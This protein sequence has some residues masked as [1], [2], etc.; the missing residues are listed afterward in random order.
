[1][2]EEITLRLRGENEDLR[3]KL[4]QSQQEVDG[5][6]ESVQKIETTS[7]GAGDAIEAAT[8]DLRAEFAAARQELDELASR[9]DQV[10]PELSH[11]PDG[12]VQGLRR[13]VDLTQEIETASLN[14]SKAFVEQSARARIAIAE[15]S[16]QVEALGTDLDPELRQVVRELES[17]F[18][19]TFRVGQQRASRFNE[20]VKQI[21][22]QTGFARTGYVDLSDAI[23]AK[24]PQAAQA[25]FGIVSALFTLRSSFKATRE[26]ID[27]LD[28]FGIDVDALSTKV[29]LLRQQAEEFVNLDRFFRDEDAV[30]AKDLANQVNILTKRGIEFIP[31]AEGIA[32]A[33]QQWS[34]QQRVLGERS[35]ETSSAI[36]ELKEQV[37]GLT[38]EQAREEIRDLVA[39][40]REL[41]GDVD[42][43][44]EGPLGEKFRDRFEIAQE[45][46]R[47]L[48]LQ[49]GDIVDD[50]DV[51]VFD[52]VGVAVTVY[53]E[54]VAATEQA[55][56]DAKDAQKLYNVELA[57]GTT[58][59]VD[60]AKLKLEELEAA[61]R[62][63]SERI[64]ELLEKALR[65]VEAPSVAPP[66]GQQGAV[67]GGDQVEKVQQ[68][69][70]E[71][72][73]LT[74]QQRDGLI[75]TEDQLT[76]LTDAQNELVV[77]QA[78][79]SRE[80]QQTGQVFFEAAERSADGQERLNDLIAGSREEVR[81]LADQLGESGAAGIESIER[82]IDTFEDFADQVGATGAD[83]ELFARGVQEELD[84]IRRQAG[85]AFDETEKSAEKGGEALDKVGDKAGDAGKKASDLGDE[86][87]ETGKKIEESARRGVGE[88]YLLTDA[89]DR[90]TD[91]CQR[92]ADCMAALGNA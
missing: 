33:M 81:A 63:S 20:E 77:A 89:L 42:V 92:L 84:R 24:S 46:A 9:T 56:K 90:A 30:A 10:E 19:S 68:L 16:Q 41:G 76:R 51:E 17:D 1:M 86:M 87:E 47:T 38:V 35:Q 28:E 7:K 60:T 66:T 49:V 34:E 71:I 58:K 8:A 80:S 12:L 75:V 3:R 27:F 48:G 50:E 14:S 37:A 73:T 18:E 13:V 36:Q 82:N 23:L 88:V 43:L 57:E 79:L 25:I 31:T 21:S 62:Q 52:R 5:L 6:R 22:K 67:P 4:Q 53:G 69:Q 78:D 15:V 11:L 85:E 59:A 44:L 91:A 74:T 55:T 2:A 29:F 54:Q 61:I 72:D 64:D 83:V 65:P 40:V 39:I 26:V 32:A 45:A 70:Q